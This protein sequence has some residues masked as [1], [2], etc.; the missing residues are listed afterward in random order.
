MRGALRGDCGAGGACRVGP[1]GVL[2]LGVGLTCRDSGLG[3]PEPLALRRV[4]LPGFGGCWWA[5][6][7]GLR[8]Q[9]LPRG[10]V[11]GLLQI[12]AYAV[13]HIAHTAALRGRYGNDGKP[14]AAARDGLADSGRCYGCRRRL[15]PITA[16]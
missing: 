1:A 8:R 15:T 2:G 10:W 9:G 16:R 4:G 11:K 14:L 5:D 12:R 13:Y 7:P 6:L 3:L